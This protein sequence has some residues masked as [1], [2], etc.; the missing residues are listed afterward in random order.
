MGVVCGVGGG[1]SCAVLVGHDAAAVH[2]DAARAPGAERAVAVGIAQG[3]VGVAQAVLLAAIAA[4]D[5]HVLVAHL[6]DA[7]GLKEIEVERVLSL[8]ER[9]VLASLLVEQAS[10]GAA[11]GDERVY[12]VRARALAVHGALVEL[13]GCGVL[14]AVEDVGAEA[15]VVV[16]VLLVRDVFDED[17]GVEV[18]ERAIDAGTSVGR[19]VHGREGSVGAVALADRRHAAP[20]AAVGIE[21]VGFL[22]RRLVLD[23]HEVGGIHGV[24]LAINKMREDGTLVAPLR[25]V[26]DGCRPHADVGPAVGGIGDVVRADDVG[27]QLAGVVGV[28]EDAGFAVGQMLPQGEVGVLG[29]RAQHGQQQGSKGNQLTGFHWGKIVK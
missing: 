1:E 12:A 6:A 5:H 9:L 29:V 21:P 3:A 24:P 25:Q 27:T 26:F 20:P 11:G 22:P 16:L 17:A 8:V 19:Q 28:F 15:L 4:E 23:L 13:D 7:A 2:E 10:V 14:E 18:D